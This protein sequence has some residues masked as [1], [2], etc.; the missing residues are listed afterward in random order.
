MLKPH[1]PFDLI[2]D[3]FYQKSDFFNEI[4]YKTVK[5]IRHGGGDSTTFSEFAKFRLILL[6]KR[7]SGL[8]D[9]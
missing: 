4:L 2:P 7:A 1:K 6:N 9:F 5:P 8:S 3:R